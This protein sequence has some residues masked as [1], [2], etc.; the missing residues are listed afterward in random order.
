MR[1]RRLH[2]HRGTVLPAVI[3]AGLFAL[4]APAPAFAHPADPYVD[5]YG[6]EICQAMDRN[7]SHREVIK[8]IATVRDYTGLSDEDSEIVV[9]YSIRR[10]CPQ[11]F[12]LIHLPP[13]PG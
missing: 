12:D 1:Y 8:A 7:P 2:H 9:V 4:A 10:D 5:K 6:T 13:S 3:F 11:Y